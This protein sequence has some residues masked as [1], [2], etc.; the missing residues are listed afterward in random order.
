M[1]RAK[2][3]ALGEQV[4]RCFDF[5][6][7]FYFPCRKSIKASLANPASRSNE[8]R[9]PSEYRDCAGEPQHAVSTRDDSLTAGSFGIFK[10]ERSYQRFVV[11]W[12]RLPVFLQTR[13]I[14]GD[15]VPGHILG[16]G[17]SSPVGY[18]T[19]Q[20]RYDGRK[21]AFGFG[22]QYDIEMTTR[23]LH[24]DSSYRKGLD[25]SNTFPPEWGAKLRPAPTLGGG[26][27]QIV[28]SS[29]SYFKGEFFARISDIVW[30]W[31]PMK[32]LA[33]FWARRESVLAPAMALS[34][35]WR[36]SS[37]GSERVINAAANSIC[38]SGPRKSSAFFTSA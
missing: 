19:R 5:Q 11:R 24:F 30:L 13:D 31:G 32:W 9:C 4:A 26:A 38:A 35:C 16:L 7:R 33:R 6:R 28:A 20:H 25:G 14:A 34:A 3:C 21:P 22:A 27:G 23:F 12:N 36:C 15:G 1:S 29:A 37:C 10:V 18:T 2:L 8:R 17:Q